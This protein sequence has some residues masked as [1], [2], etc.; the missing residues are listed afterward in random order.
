MAELGDKLK[1]AWNAFKNQDQMKEDYGGTSY[2]HGSFGS[3]PSHTHTIAYNRKQLVS[4]IY[5]RLTVDV[6]AL[7]IRHVRV[8]ETDQYVEDIDSKLNYCLGVS[9]NIDQSAR[10]LIQDVAWTLFDEGQA[11]IIPMET[12]LNP[13]NTGGYDIS[14]LRCGSVLEYLNDN[15]VRLSAYNELTRQREQLIMPKKLVAIVYNPFYAVMNEPNSTLQRLIRKLQL[16][17][18]VDEASASGKLD[19]IIQ[20]PYVIKS[21]A[22]REQ[23]EQRA[24]DIDL[25]LKTNSHGI[26][27]TDGTEKITQL[28]RPAESQLWAQVEKLTAMLY[29]E[30]GLTAEILNR[31][32]GES[33]MLNYHTGTIEPVAASIV[34]AMHRTFLTKTAITQGQ[35]IRAF[36]DPFRFVPMEKIAEIA[37][38]FTRNEILSANELRSI[39]GI[40]PSKDPKADELRNSN[41]PDP[42]PEPKPTPK[43]PPEEEEGDLQNGS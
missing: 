29:D 43:K 37:D 40:R 1:H 4:S 6:A 19:L 42:N 18:K 8:N 20:L 12:D 9:A 27:Y 14:D 23:A 3:R 32:A 13:L 10:A 41:M 34:D 24:R 28:N 33:T 11:A 15:M 31:T 2:S 35:R 39:I 38:K 5:N 7:P 26:A 16:L 30:L 36:R 22:R 21:Q 25:Q 17:D